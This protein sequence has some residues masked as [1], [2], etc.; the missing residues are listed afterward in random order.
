MGNLGRFSLVVLIWS[1]LLDQSFAGLLYDK[2][3]C[4]S[5]ADTRGAAWLT[6]VTNMAST[7]WNLMDATEK[8]TAQ[9]W[10]RYRTEGAYDAF[11]DIFHQ[12]S[13]NRW[14]TVKGQ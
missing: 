10:D 9:P 7:A 5:N 14:K 8:G 6:D 4:G 3:T 13:P 1:I 11:F 2:A 12:D